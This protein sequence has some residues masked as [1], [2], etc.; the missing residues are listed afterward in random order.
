MVLTPDRAIVNVARIVLLLVTFGVSAA[1]EP[2]QG[3]AK[4]LKGRWTAVLII[5][6]GQPAKQDAVRN[7]EAT[8]DGRTYTNIV[9]GKLDRGGNVHSRRFESPKTIDFHITTG[10]DQGKQQLAIYKLEGERLTMVF[11]EPGSS[12]RPKSF[13]PGTSG[14]AVFT[15]AKY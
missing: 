10:P 2:K 1:D 12:E 6:R 8:F 11:S 13:D 14:E 15:R 3:G 7:F 5:F 4:D 9:G